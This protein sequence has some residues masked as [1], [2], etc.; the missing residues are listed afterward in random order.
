[1]LS[2]SKTDVEKEHK[3]FLKSSQLPMEKSWEIVYNIDNLIRKGRLAYD[4]QL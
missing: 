3:I 4:N 1:M 2:L